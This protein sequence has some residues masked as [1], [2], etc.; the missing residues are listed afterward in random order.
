MLDAADQPTI[1]EILTDYGIADLL[2]EREYANL[3][4]ALENRDNIMRTD[5]AKYEAKKIFM[6]ALDKIIKEV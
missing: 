2:G 6:A 4:A 1:D 3:M 5:A